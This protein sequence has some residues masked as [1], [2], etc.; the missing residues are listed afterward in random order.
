MNAVLDLSRHHAV[1]GLEIGRIYMGNYAGLALEILKGLLRRYD[2]V[3]GVI[4]VV[5]VCA[6]HIAV[7]C[8]V[9]GNAQKR[10]LACIYSRRS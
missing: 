10:R 5:C 4:H 8:S 2:P 7:A 1:G 9:F 6:Q 3:H